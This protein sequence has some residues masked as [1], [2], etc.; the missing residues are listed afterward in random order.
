MRSTPL[1]VLPRLPEGPIGLPTRQLIGILVGH[2]GLVSLVL[3]TCTRM[4]SGTHGCLFVNATRK[5]GYSQMTAPYPDPRA[6]PSV[7]SC[8]RCPG[9]ARD[10]TRNLACLVGAQ[11]TSAR[12]EQPRRAESNQRRAVKKRLA[13]KKSG[14]K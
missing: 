8:E 12:S 6:D 10:G 5:G 3:Q 7:P 9:T 4:A 11:P 2:T 1:C 14:L 13:K